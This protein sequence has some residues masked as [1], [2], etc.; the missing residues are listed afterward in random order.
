M[1]SIMFGFTAH[2]SQ[3]C[4]TEHSISSLSNEG[5]D[6]APPQQMHSEMG[7]HIVSRDLTEPYTPGVGQLE[8]VR[9]EKSSTSDNAKV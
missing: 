3:V 2:I 1:P 7:D 8:F 6:A 4:R 5:E 9:H